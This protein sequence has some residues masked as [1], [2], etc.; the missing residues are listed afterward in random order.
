MLPLFA[1][2]L[3]AALSLRS[4]AWIAVMAAFIFSSNFWLL[5]N[6]LAPTRWNFLQS[7]LLFGAM[8]LLLTLYLLRTRSQS[9]SYQ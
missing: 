3:P 5:A 7:Y 9:P 2:A 6:R 4:R 8:I 1:L